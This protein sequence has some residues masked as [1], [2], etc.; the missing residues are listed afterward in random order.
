MSLVVGYLT[1]FGA[2]DARLF[3]TTPSAGE[4]ITCR[5]NLEEFAVWN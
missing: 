1:L 2:P 4:T 5:H 3:T